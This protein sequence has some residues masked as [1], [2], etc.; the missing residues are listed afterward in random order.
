VATPANWKDGD[1]V[2]ISPSIPDHDTR[3]VSKGI[4]KKL[5]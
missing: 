5:I 1:D 2:V 4:S 3:E